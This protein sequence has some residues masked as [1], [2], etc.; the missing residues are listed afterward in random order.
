[1]KKLQPI[2]FQ[3]RM[4]ERNKTRLQTSANRAER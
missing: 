1:V 3:S 2:L 4:L